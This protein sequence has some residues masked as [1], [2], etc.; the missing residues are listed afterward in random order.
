[1]DLKKLP[2]KELRELEKRTMISIRT[3]VG[4]EEQNKLAKRLIKIRKILRGKE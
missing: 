4:R 1:M 2:R 3:V